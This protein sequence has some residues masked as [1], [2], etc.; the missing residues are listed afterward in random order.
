MIHKKAIFATVGLAFVGMIASVPTVHAVLPP[1]VK[2]YT[3]AKGNVTGVWN[4]P[5]RYFVFNLNTRGPCGGISFLV[6]RTKENYKEM[7]AMVLTAIAANK[8]VGA[9]VVDCGNP[10]GNPSYSNDKNIISHGFIIP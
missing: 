6:D 5:V 2:A 10:S 3:E 8:Q 9:Y 1:G 4:D 7:V